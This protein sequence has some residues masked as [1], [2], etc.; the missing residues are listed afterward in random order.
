[1][2]FGDFETGGQCGGVVEAPRRRENHHNPTHHVS[3]SHATKNRPPSKSCQYPAPFP[4]FLHFFFTSAPST[5]HCSLFNVIQ[6]TVSE[7]SPFFG[8]QS[9]ETNQHHRFFFACG[10]A[11]HHECSKN[12][13]KHAETQAIGDSFALNVVFRVGL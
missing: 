4:A 13:E 6:I 2:I 10:C 8:V 1:V 11:F 12:Q 5:V 9:H 3:R 7:N